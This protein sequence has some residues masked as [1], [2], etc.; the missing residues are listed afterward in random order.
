MAMFRNRLLVKGQRPD[1]NDTTPGKQ[2]AWKA[3][4]PVSVLLIDPST[5]FREGLKRLLDGSPFAVSDEADSTAQALAEP[6]PD[7]PPE[8]IL[9]DPEGDA[10][11]EALVVRGLRTAYP[12][13]RLVILSS[14]PQPLS[15]SPAL[16]AGA[17]GYLVKN[18]GWKTLAQVLQN[19][20][21]T[22]KSASPAIPTGNKVPFKTPAHSRSLS[23]REV[24]VLRCLINGHSNKTIATQLSITEATVKVHL[25]NLLRK[26]DTSNRTQAAIW[27]LNNGLKGW[28]RK[29][30]AAPRRN[31]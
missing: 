3:M 30:C 15:P 18:I 8:L 17:D 22:K 12:K 31:T 19:L 11:G 29:P 27:A 24:Q 26:L 10:L 28:S 1:R 14:A 5:L 16:E 4:H 2:G 25:K 23:Q 13:S 20:M 6:A 7:K 9:V 21:M